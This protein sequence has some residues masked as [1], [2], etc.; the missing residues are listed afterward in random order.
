MPT[1]IFYSVVFVS[2]MVTTALY[3]TRHRWLDRIPQP[4]YTRL[5]SFTHDIEEGFTS[6]DFDLS[7]NIASGDTRAG[8]D[9]AGKAEVRK[10]MKAKRVGFDEARRLYT[11]SKFA[12]NNIGPD[13][14]PRDPKFVSFS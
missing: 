7:T 10:I 14:R 5:Q 6:E 4:L 3:F 8:L 13:G 11:E 12:K 1:V 2:L 9:E